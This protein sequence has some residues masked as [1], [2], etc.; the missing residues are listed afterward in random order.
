VTLRTWLKCIEPIKSLAMADKASF[1]NCLV[2]MRPKAVTKDIPSTHNV[3]TYIHNQFVKRL[4]E[5]KGDIL[6]S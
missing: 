5:L 4:E 2:A 1:R 3:T 6:V